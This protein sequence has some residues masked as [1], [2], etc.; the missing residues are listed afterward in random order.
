MNM[1]KTGILSALLALAT[2]AG[3]GGDDSF[4]G[5]GAAGP[6]G[7]ATVGSLTLITSSPTVPSDGTTPATI[8][9]FVRDANNNFLKDVPVVFSASSG[10]MLIT[11]GTTDVN[12][13]A[14]A[15]LNSAGDPSRRTITVTAVA[16]NITRTLNIDVTGSTLSV[17]GPA[18]L[19]LSQ[20]GTYTVT[21]LDSGSRPVANQAVTVASAR[22]NTLSAG[23]VTTNANGTAT[24]NMTAANG[25]ND[26]ITVT[27]IGLTSTQAVAVNSDNFTITAPAANTEVALGASQT[28]TARW[29]VNNAPVVGQT[30]NFATTRGTLSASSAV[31]DAS[32]NASVSVSAA[33][34]GGAVVSATSGTSTAQVS[35]E[36]VALTPSQID[37]QPSVFTLATTQTSTITAVV[38]D[39][40]GNLVKNVTVVFTLNDVTGG[41]LSRGSAVTDSQG[42]AQ[43][44][45]TASSTT[46]ANE[47]VKITGTVQ[48]T[49]ITKTV[50]LTVARREV[51][52]SIGTGNS[53]EEPNTA[54]YKIEYIVQVTDSNGNGVAN[55]PVS[56]RILSDRYYKGFR[57]AALAPANGWTTQYSVAGGCADEDSVPVPG[58]PT[59]L[60]NGILDTGEDFNNSGRLEAGN[61]ASVTPSN[62]VTDT[63]G[64][65]LV[66]VFYPQEY[67]YY[68]DVSLSAS[69]T[70]QGTE[71]VRTSRFMLP[72]IASDFN[73]RDKAPPGPS[74]PFGTAG[75]CNS[76]F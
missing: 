25:G 56:L 30:V 19:T 48:G 52:I 16:A 61:I 64:F 22:S 1:R 12:G 66:N 28:V 9:A 3:C 20:Q 76:P 70:V 4:G 49:A 37:V 8:S 60:R 6:G 62:A 21:L 41:T 2:L 67:A 73:D 45:Y 72:G 58:Q 53:L 27:A 51:F 5:G 63:N 29:L 15:T 10:G 11:Q 24:F 36:F 39:A 18:A 74:S 71:Y 23:T 43:T 38:R 35:L 65:V 13:L 32:G 75:S 31:T 68:L 7:P 46:S 69:S 50:S 55:V 42:R 59:F 40:A 26:T 14:T 33:N 57:L 34:A 47:G 44:I 17:Q 54:Q